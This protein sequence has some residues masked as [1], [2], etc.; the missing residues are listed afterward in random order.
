VSIR[1]SG[2]ERRVVDGRLASRSC[3]PRR[4]SDARPD[5]TE[6]SAA[7]WFQPDHAHEL[8]MH[9]TMRPRVD[10]ALNHPQQVHFD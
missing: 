4:T 6:T 2:N 3:Q 1:W 9:P 5:R 7:D 8:P 10:H